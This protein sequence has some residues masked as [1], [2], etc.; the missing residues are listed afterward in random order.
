MPGGDQGTSDRRGAKVWA[1]GAG[2]RMVGDRGGKASVWHWEK[3][4]VVGGRSLL[5]F[6]PETGRTHR[7]RVHALEGLGFAIAGDP[8]YGSGGARGRTLLHAERLVVN[9]D[10]KPPIIAEAPFPDHFAAL[11]FAAP[12]GA[13][14][15]RG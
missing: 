8:V 15:T 11:G 1:G 13:E 12:E 5:G 2:W 10:V 4:A 3:L 6:R 14:P 7:L 9:R